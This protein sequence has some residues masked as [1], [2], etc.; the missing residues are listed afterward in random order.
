MMKP[1]AIYE[2]NYENVPLQIKPSTT[3]EVRLPFH[4]HYGS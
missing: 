2:N 4:S 1:Q 3:N